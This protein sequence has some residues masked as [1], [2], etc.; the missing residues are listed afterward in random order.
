MKITIISPFFPYPKRG[1]FFGAERYTEN[2]A[3][4]LK[5]IG[6]DIKIVT[7]FWYGGKRYDTYNGIPILRILDSKAL[8]GNFGVKY[9]FS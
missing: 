4:S 6:F 9:F 5:E 7:S 3:F 1:D 8:F 2:L